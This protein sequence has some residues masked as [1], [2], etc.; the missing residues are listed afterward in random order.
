M[1]AGEVVASMCDKKLDFGDWDGEDAGKPWARGMRQLLKKRDIES[2]TNDFDAEDNDIEREELPACMPSG[3]TEVETP[4][5]TAPDII[6]GYDSDDSLTGYASQDSSRSASPSPSDLAEIEATA[7]KG[8]V[9]TTVAFV[10]AAVLAVT[11]FVATTVMGTVVTVP[12]AGAFV[13]DLVAVQF[14]VETVSLVVGMSCAMNFY[15]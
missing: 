8:I 10:A 3:R 13:R 12:A 7:L 2:N 14:V 1:L 11:G 6:N 15:Y 9:V 5:V 4:I